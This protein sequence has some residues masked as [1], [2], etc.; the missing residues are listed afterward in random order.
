MWLEKLKDLKK[1]KG[2]TTKQIADITKIPESTLK[3]IFSGDTPDPYI[4]T[5]HRIVTAL[6]G[7][8]DYI[9]ADTNAVITA[10]KANTEAG[11]KIEELKATIAEQETKILLLEERLKHKE[12]ILAL[13]DYFAKIKKE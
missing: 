11:D 5:I 2:M 10:E 8:L 6:G 7:S 13:I 9:L 1:A 4:S 3:R 12:E